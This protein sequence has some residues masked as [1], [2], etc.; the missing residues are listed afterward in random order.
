[1]KTFNEL[2]ADALKRITEIFPWDLET[3]LENSA[4]PPLLVDIREPYEFQA[5]HIQGAINVPSGILETAAEE[6]YEDTVPE[7]AQARE[8]EVILI[9]R[10]GNRSVLAADT[11]Q[12]MGF[13]RV[14]SVKT[15]MRGWSD[16]D[17]PIYGLE[18]DGKTP[19]ID[20][21]LAFETFNQHPRPEQMRP[22]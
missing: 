22:S 15:G 19:L 20:S 12:Q 8:A 14:V 7:L 11:L 16:D 9:C 10:S 13:Q 1:M 17:R 6:D 5:G 21:D 18:I 2:I 4:P 3:I